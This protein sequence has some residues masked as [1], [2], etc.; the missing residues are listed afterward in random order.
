MKINADAASD[1]SVH[2]A[3]RAYFK[4]MED[5]M[6]P[7][8]LGAVIFNMRVRRRVRVEAMEDMARTFDREV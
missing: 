6:S 4:R 3:A 5:G 7:L 8:L 1:E 2:D